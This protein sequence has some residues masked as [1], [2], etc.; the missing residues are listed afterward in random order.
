LGYKICSIKIVKANKKSDVKKVLL[1][2]FGKLRNIE[3]VEKINDWTEDSNNLYV[4]EV[5]YRVKLTPEAKKELS[6][7]NASLLLA[8]LIRICSPNGKMQDFCVGKLAFKK[9]ENGWTFIKRT[10]SS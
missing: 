2:L 10:S 6:T 7:V 8:P 5:K 4:M 1:N 9:T 3:N